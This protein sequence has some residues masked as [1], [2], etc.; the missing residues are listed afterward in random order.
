MRGKF[1]S[2]YMGTAFF[3]VV[4]SLVTI[5]R[6]EISESTSEAE[7]YWFEPSRGYFSKSL[8]LRDLWQGLVK[9][10]KPLFVTGLM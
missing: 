6:Y 9:E 10:C 2:T 1:A 8:L 5:K 7:G 4:V 3:G